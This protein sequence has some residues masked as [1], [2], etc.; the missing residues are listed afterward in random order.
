MRVREVMTQILQMVSLMAVAQQM[1][2]WDV[3][4]VPVCDRGRLVGVVTERDVQPIGL[5]PT[6][7]QALSHG[8]VDSFASRL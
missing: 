2:D 6:A 4:S 1:L 5:D 3:H 8:V 7:G